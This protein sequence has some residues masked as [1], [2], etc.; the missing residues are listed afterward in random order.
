MID[1]PQ[2]AAQQNN[3]CEQR[4]REEG[5]IMQCAIIRSRL[6]FIPVLLASCRVSAQHIALRRQPG[7]Q[8][9]VCAEE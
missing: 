9:A 6:L 7:E 5:G 1:I 4:N 8:R 3:G 2:L